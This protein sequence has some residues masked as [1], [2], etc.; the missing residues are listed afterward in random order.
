MIPNKQNKSLDLKRQ[1]FSADSDLLT[2][3]RTVAKRDV[4]PVAATPV[5]AW[6]TSTGN[7]LWKVF[8]EIV[9]DLS[10]ASDD[11]DEEESGPEDDGDSLSIKRSNI[12][13][14][15]FIVNF[16][17]IDILTILIACLCDALY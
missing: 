6:L 4:G 7:V 12:F 1:P 2:D 5:L 9:D 8:R 17:N 14:A 13:M 16:V 3:S 15:F 10:L 11:E